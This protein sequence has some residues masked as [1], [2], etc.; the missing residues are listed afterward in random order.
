MKSDAGEDFDIVL[1]R[2]KE[3]VKTVNACVGSTIHLRVSEQGL[4]GQA[5]IV[6]IED[7]PEITTGDGELVTG[8]FTHVRGGILRLHLSGISEPLCVT[9]NHT[10]YSET[11]RDFVH[12]EELQINERL[13]H[14]NGTTEI[15]QID[16]MHTSERVYNLEI[17]H[18]HVFRVTPAGVLVH[19]NSEIVDLWKAPQ[20]GRSGAAGEVV[21][22]FLPENYPGEGVF[23]A[24][25]E[26][27]AGEYRFNYQ[28]GMQRVRIPRALYDQLV[29]EG[30]IL[31]DE[32]L[33]NSAIRVPP[34]KLPRFNEAMRQGP[35][36][37][38]SP[39]GSP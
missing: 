25:A 33:P 29:Q 22:G 32:N 31:P 23:F 14:L 26:A 34:D 30:V 36:N 18:D 38:Y 19:N 5:R 12:A 20:P 8:T 11:R 27:K 21:D 1:L 10:V 24:L 2:S 13:L 28:N 3:W 15:L 37:E 9:E 35:P 17:N 16:R 6:A 4:D 39:E 7:R